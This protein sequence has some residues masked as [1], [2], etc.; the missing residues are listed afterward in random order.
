MLFRERVHR[1]TV[2]TLFEDTS[3]LFTRWTTS[4]GGG[5]VCPAVEETIWTLLARVSGAGIVYFTINP[6]WDDDVTELQ[7]LLYEHGLTLI[8]PS[9]RRNHGPFVVPISSREHLAAIVQIWNHDAPI[10]P[11]HNFRI[12]APRP[13]SFNRL[14]AQAGALVDAD[15]KSE[16]DMLK[17]WE[18]ASDYVVADYSEGLRN[19]LWVH[20][21]D[22]RR[23][24][25]ARE[26]IAEIW[27]S[28][29]VDVGSAGT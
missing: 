21:A 7:D 10:T 13:S 14:V 15:Y 11:S 2:Y 26:G 18:V 8:T 1:L 29:G 20:S 27:R 3:L 28:Q 5:D 4:Y 9:K 22:R 17:A 25:W 16:K 6:V 23:M 24:E 19:E 12:F